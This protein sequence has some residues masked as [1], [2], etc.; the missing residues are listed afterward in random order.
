LYEIF[1]IEA[2][3]NEQTNKYR[4]KNEQDTIGNKN[5]VFNDINTD[6]EHM[7]KI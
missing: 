4:N 5:H 3:T 2:L 7:N 6:Y 1:Q